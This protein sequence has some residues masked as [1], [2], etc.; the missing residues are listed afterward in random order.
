[1]VKTA[2]CAF[3]LL[4]LP[5]ASARADTSAENR[6]AAQA[7]FDQ[8]RSLVKAGRLPEACPKFEESQR[9]DPSIGTE[10]N[11]ADCFE[12]TGRTASAWTLYVDV[13]SAARQAGQEERA[14]HAASRVSALKDKLSRLVIVVPKESRIAGLS[15]QRGT[16]LVGEAQWDAAMPVD[17]GRQKVTVSAPGKATW[18]TSIDIVA[19]GATRSVSVPVLT[20]A[21]PS[22]SDTIPMTTPG[23]P[24][25]GGGGSSQKKVAF[26][27]GG[28]GIAGLV[29]GGIF[30][31]IVAGKKGDAG[32]DTNVCA[33]ES[34][35][36][37][38]RQA[39]KAGNVSTVAFVLGGVALA[40]GA[41]LYFTA[42]KS[43]SLGARFGVQAA[44]TPGAVGFST[45][46]SW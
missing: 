19:D 29:V 20:D 31:A 6:A 32:C 44:I 41:V 46:A 40:G 37:S 38:Y 23:E 10:L 1:M 5:M 17:P 28:I 13:A 39:Q 14:A 7:L 33:D 12:R 18:Q 26:V 3:A 8:G 34:H 24:G 2:G 43:S 25:T 42:P 36:E 27:A 35:A 22:A 16:L 11:L 9:L 15:V 45:G 21:A 30:G 4:V